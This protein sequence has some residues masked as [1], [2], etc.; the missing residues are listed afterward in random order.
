MSDT[1][2]LRPP[3]WKAWLLFFGSAAFTLVGLWL[4]IEQ[5]DIKNWLGVVFFGLCWVVA[6]T[7]VLPGSTCLRLTLE[8]FETISLFRSS[9][10]PWDA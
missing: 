2:V 7:M 8:G 3:K 6:A 5:G 4:L 9:L 1:L 10:T